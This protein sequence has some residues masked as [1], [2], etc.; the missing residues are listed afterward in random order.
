MKIST[1]H[2]VTNTSKS[3]SKAN[4]SMNNNPTNITKDKIPSQISFSAQKFPSGYY[5]D[6]F[7]AFVKKNIMDKTSNWMYEHLAEFRKETKQYRDWPTL[8]ISIDKDVELRKK[9]C[10]GLLTDLKAK[11][12]ITSI[13]EEDFD[14]P[15]GVFSSQQDYSRRWNHVPQCY[16]KSEQV[17]DAIDPYDAAAYHARNSWESGG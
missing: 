14:I 7:V 1:I 16:I 5:S 17:E 2:N 8:A 13:A 4:N 12:N 15:S 6:W 10:E 11:K 9:D 3:N